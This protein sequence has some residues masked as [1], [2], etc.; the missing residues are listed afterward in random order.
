MSVTFYYPEAREIKKI[1]KYID[2]RFDSGEHGDSYWVD[3]CGERISADTGYAHEWW[4]NCMKPELEDL[5]EHLENMPDK[6][7]DKWLN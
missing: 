6:E 2:E 5:I 4:K 3:H 7:K 1:I